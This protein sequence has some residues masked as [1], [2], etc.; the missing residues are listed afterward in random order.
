MKEVWGFGIEF[1][2]R[3]YFLSLNAIPLHSLYNIASVKMLGFS[4]KIGK[5]SVEEKAQICGCA[6]TLINTFLSL[7][8]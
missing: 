3:T 4:N 5:G 2:A 8:L 1:P 7:M 6:V